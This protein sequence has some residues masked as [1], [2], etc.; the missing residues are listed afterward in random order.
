M[1]ATGSGESGGRICQANEVSKVVIPKTQEDP[2]AGAG[3]L[4]R[5]ERRRSVCRSAPSALYLSDLC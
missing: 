2:L 1:S 5:S 4:L 3:V